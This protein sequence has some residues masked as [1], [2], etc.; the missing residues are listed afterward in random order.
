MIGV[1]GRPTAR[2]LTRRPTP[3][4]QDSS[5]QLPL[6]PVRQVFEALEDSLQARQVLR[7]GDNPSDS[8]QYQVVGHGKLHHPK[9]SNEDQGKGSDACCAQTRQEYDSRQVGLLFVSTPH[10]HLAP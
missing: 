9:E 3:K 8:C 5:S 2:G 1:S 10:T 7:L 6:L 4:I